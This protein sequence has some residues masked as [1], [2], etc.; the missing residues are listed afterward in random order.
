[1]KIPALEP[2]PPSGQRPEALE[3]GGPGDEDS[4]F[5]TQGVL[6]GGTVFSCSVLD[7]LL[8]SVGSGGMVLTQCSLARCSRCLL[9]SLGFGGMVLTQSSLAR[10]SRC[11]FTNSW[12]WW[13]CTY[14][15]FP[16]A[17]I[18]IKSCTRAQ[19]RRDAQTVYHNRM[20]AAHA[21]QADYPRVRTFKSSDTSTNNVFEDLREAEK[22]SGMEGKVDVGDLTWEQRERVL[23]LLFAKMNGQKDRKKKKIPALEPTPS[24][25]QRPEALE[26]GGPGDEDSTFITL[27]VLT[28]GT[29]NQQ[30]GA[31]EPTP[32]ALPP[33]GNRVAG[34]V[35]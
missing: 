32:P 19:Y 12:F 26:S 9:L 31:L 35:S 18:D 23:R 1:K 29:G 34:L 33:S 10:C 27:G 22:W 8:L 15:E 24:S 16:C 7:V 21:G 3:S 28:G 2:T 13:Y 11:F 5:I 20:L 30:K 4:T 14:P 17:L 6:T 25:G